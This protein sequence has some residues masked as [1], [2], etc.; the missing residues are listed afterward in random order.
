MVRLE[1]RAAPET[2]VTISLMAVTVNVSF[3]Q[4]V[5]LSADETYRLLCDWEDHGRWVPLTR[6]VVHSEEAF[7]AYTGIG[8]LRL[9]DD[10]VVQFRDDAARHVVVEKIGPV[11]TGT[12]GFAVRNFSADACVVRWTESLRIPLL[13]RFL[14]P[15]LRTVTRRLF[16]RALRRLA[17]R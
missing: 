16:S 13:P 3:D 5:G 4:H 14:A 7:T 12:A 9:R 6:V 11:L 15:P 1:R 8:P 2:V 10:M 17:P